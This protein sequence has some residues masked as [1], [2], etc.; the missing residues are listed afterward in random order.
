MLPFAPRALTS[1]NI[2]KSKIGY[3]EG[4][5]FLICALSYSMLELRSVTELFIFNL[6]RFP[7]NVHLKDQ[8]G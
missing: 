2:K 6:H 7:E 5:N 4:S 3:L 8:N 1:I